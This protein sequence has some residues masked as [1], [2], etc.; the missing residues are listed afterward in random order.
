MLAGSDD[1]VVTR[2]AGSDNLC[3][4]DGKHR[5]E[6]VCVVAVLAYVAG[7][8]MRRILARCV[9]AVVAINAVASNVDVIEIGRQ[10]ALC[11]VTI[12]TI[13]PARD[14]RQV[15]ARGR[16][17]IMAGAARSYDLG[18]VDHGHG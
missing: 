16:N 10:P 3:M 12:V 17:S 2:I 8:N 9:H 15:L 1:T 14:V 7:L 5:R 18:V 13:V 6:H 11:R 4:V